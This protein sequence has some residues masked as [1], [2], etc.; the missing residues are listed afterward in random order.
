[1]A[2]YN[3]R[4]I[5]H[6]AGGDTWLFSWWADSTSSLASVHGAAST[7]ADDFWAGPAGTNGYATVCAPEI[8]LDQVTTGLMDEATGRQLELAET[9]KAIVGTSVAGTNVADVAIVVS[10]RTTLANRRGR[11]R[12]YL[13]QPD[14]QEINLNGNMGTT[15]VVL[16]L[17]ALNFAWGTYTITAAPVVYS[18]INRS[19]EIVTS[20]DIGNKYDTQRGRESGLAVTRSTRAMP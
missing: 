11:G 16:L 13:P 8:G 10:L 9:A 3:H 14:N 12:F 20:F 1:M 18:R 15:R 4:F 7:W 17:D 6:T 5:G 2:L 19:T